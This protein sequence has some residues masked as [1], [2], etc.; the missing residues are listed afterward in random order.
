MKIELPRVQSFEFQSGT[1]ELWGMLANK[2]NWTEE[3]I[4]Q[5]GPH[6]LRVTLLLVIGI[7][8]S[9][10]ILRNGTKWSRVFFRTGPVVP[11][12]L[13]VGTLITFLVLGSLM[14]FGMG[15]APQERD[16]G[17]DVISSYEIGS[18]Y[19]ADQIPPGSKF[20]WIGGLST[21]PLLYLDD[22]E[23][24]PPQIND[25]YSYRLAGNPDELLRYG[26]WNAELAQQWYDD[27]DVILVEAS[28][29]DQKLDGI[30]LGESSPTTPM[31][32]CRSNSSIHIYWREP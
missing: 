20:F 3:Q 29:Y 18:T 25:K 12:K 11:A 19:L 30:I 7:I 5:T 8:F 17:W 14:T 16:C 22:V 24:Y 4:F 32:P 31:L 13:S 15:L 9:I 28:L 10:I 23:I 2:F 1:V 27:A 21:I 6:I 26:W